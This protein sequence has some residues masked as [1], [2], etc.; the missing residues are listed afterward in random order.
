MKAKSIYAATVIRNFADSKKNDL[1]QY[2]MAVRLNAMFGISTLPSKFC[3]NATIYYEWCMDVIKKCRQL[4]SFPNVKPKEIYGIIFLI[5]QPNVEKLYINFN[6]KNIWKNLN[7]KYIN[8]YD[9]HILYKYIHEILPNNKK[10]YN[11]G[12]RISPNCE[13][14]EL[15]ETNIHM[16]LY[17]YKV[18]SCVDLVYRILYYFCN[19]NFKD[20]LLKLLFFEF[21]RVDKR[22]QNTIC[23]TMSSYISCIWY[24]RDNS[25]HL[26]NK[27]KSKIIREQKY[28]KLVLKEKIQ[29]IF[30]ENYC[31]I[32]MDIL[33]NL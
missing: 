5:T 30:T 12:S 15:E 24:N 1:I 22:I 29:D 31:N 32:D 4:N 26:L 25:E 21:P 11:M 13:I 9:R 17:C 20:H 8:I 16:F 18:Q 14:C 23:I 3:Y 10:L 7:F 33:N 6:W 28:H 27:L 19:M 2:Y